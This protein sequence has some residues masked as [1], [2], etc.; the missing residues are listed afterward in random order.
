MLVKCL[1]KM[2]VQLFGQDL[3]QT[4]N[5]DFGQTEQKQQHLLQQQSGAR[6]WVDGWVGGGELI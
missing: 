3:G 6:L 4:F 1:V 2:F 5:Q